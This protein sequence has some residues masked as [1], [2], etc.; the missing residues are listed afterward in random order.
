[1]NKMKNQ[2]SVGDKH[3]LKLILR[4]KDSEGWTKVSSTVWP[5]VSRLPSQLVELRKHDDGGG[6]VKLTHDGEVVCEWT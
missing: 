3:L 5:Y 6:Q 2:L 4:D 1:M